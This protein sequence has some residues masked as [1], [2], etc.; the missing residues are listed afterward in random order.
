MSTRKP[1]PKLILFDMDSTLVKVSCWH[2]EAL[3]RTLLSVYGLD[4]TE[5]YMLG[6]HAGDTQTNLVRSV[7]R[8]AGLDEERI[9]AGLPEVAV[10]LAAT[11]VQVLP[12]DLRAQALPGAVPLLETLQR[13]GQA[14]GLVTG[15]LSSI[16]QTILE[17]ADLLRFFPVRACGD[18]RRE[19]EELVRLAIER[20]RQFYRFDVEARDVV[21]L[22]DAPLDI[23][24]GRAVGARV[25]A[26]ATG[27][28]SEE[29]L[30]SLRPDAVLPSLKDWNRA[31][32]TILDGQ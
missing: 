23:Q 32:Q 17:R 15:T 12:A 9:E 25:I 20:A 4:P 18:E 19:R 6:S 8:Q 24:A 21:V 28:H 29:T 2:W 1:R 14:L 16:A 10:T 11:T 31:L 5:H 7:C 22:G 27:A 30:A 13:D 3:V 26:V